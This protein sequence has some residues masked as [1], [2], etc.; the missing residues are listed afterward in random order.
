M[1]R[2][3]QMEPETGAGK[4]IV[5]VLILGGGG[6]ARV[7]ADAMMR[8]SASVTGMELIGFLDDDPSVRRQHIMG[9]PVLG[10]VADL[11]QIPHDAIVIG[12]GDNEVR[13][14]LFEKFSTQG[15][16][17]ITVI[18]P[19]ATIASEVTVGLG[20]VVFAGVV[21]N[22]GTKISDNVILNTAC[23]VDHDCLV[24]SHAHI[25]PGAHLG[26]TVRIG[27]GAFVGIGCA[28]IHNRNVGEWA[29]VGGGAAVT[30]DVPTRTTVVGVPARVI[31]HHPVAVNELENSF[32]TVL[33]ESKEEWRRALSGPCDFYHLSFYHELARD[34]GHGEPRLFVYE[35]GRYRISLPLLIRPIDVPEESSGGT[36]LYDAT[37]VYGYAGPVASHSDIPDHIRR[38]F[39][40]SLTRALREMKVVSLFSRLHP[41]FDQSSLLSG[42]GVIVNNGNTVSIDLSLPEELQLAQYRRDHRH[43]V[44][45]LLGMGATCEIDTELKHLEA[46]IDMYH[47][48]MERVGA[49]AEYFF[50]R[51]YF[52]T[53]MT[54]SEA[55]AR[56]FVCTIQGKLACA[57]IFMKC[58]KII[59]YHLSAT[60]EE[61]VK[62]APTKLL[63]D[64][65]RRWGVEQG[66]T[67]LHLG[68][69]VGS[70]VD[71]LFE[72]KAG[73]S[74]IRHEFS[75]WRWILSE[76]EYR[77][78]TSSRTGEGEMDINQSLSSEFFPAYRK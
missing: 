58:G 8:C 64:T 54:T 72:F 42:L 1:N 76:S 23:T 70:S 24:D 46:F 68:G 27:E 65:A 45:K 5:R 25:C 15:E 19:H 48:N 7:V 26:G 67:T 29:I 53:L 11:N 77:K 36:Q 2:K 9:K 57:S 75:T 10:T 56:L 13:R 59:Q 12:I 41:L 69:G 17:F 74:E 30:K 47:R 50:P 66:A 37:S 35:S 16:T 55:M 28:I 4:K 43:G 22:T 61:F 73:F 62:Y 52:Q 6:H 20:T 38:D 40:E 51:S 39:Q 49:K 71:S 78:L 21:V 32:R 44:R 3:P 34:L 63:L 31:K 33:L 18:H 60:S 14:Q